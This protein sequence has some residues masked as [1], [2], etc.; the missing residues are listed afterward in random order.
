MEGSI[1]KDV[2]WDHWFQPPQDVNIQMALQVVKRPFVVTR[3]PIMTWASHFNDASLHEYE[4][5]DKARIAGHVMSN[6]ISY[7]VRQGGLVPYYK[8][9][10]FRADKDTVVALGKFLDLPLFAPGQKFANEYD[11]KEAVIA[12]DVP[13]IKEI[14]KDTLYW[15]RFVVELTPMIREYYESIGYD[16]WWT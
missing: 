11:L 13:R 15:E 1:D 12:K 3:D 8:L 4:G 2:L 7:Y 6:L 14:C 10:A 5:W 9:P 16:I